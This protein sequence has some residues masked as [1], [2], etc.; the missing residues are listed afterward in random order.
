MINIT[1][2][3]HGE[4]A[5]F[6]ELAKYGE[7][8]WTDKDYLIVCGDFGYLFLNNSMDVLSGHSFIYSIPQVLFTI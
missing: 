6:D 5:R 8:K 2:D 1:G 4:K 3:T 7:T